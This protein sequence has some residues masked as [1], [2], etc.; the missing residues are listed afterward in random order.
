MVAHYIIRQWGLRRYTLDSKT[1]S[2]KASWSPI[3]LR[4]LVA[5][6]PCNPKARWACLLA[7]Y[8]MKRY[9][10]DPVLGVYG[11]VPGTLEGGHC[12]GCVADS[13]GY[14]VEIVGLY[15]STGAV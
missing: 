10:C 8:V 13:Q 14:G 12:N 11:L 7:P 3:F 4:F 6:W 5:R 2:G 1:A 15:I 9:S